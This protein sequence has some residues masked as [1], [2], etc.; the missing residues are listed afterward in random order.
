MKKQISRLVLAIL[1]C[2]ML[3]VSCGG[4]GG[5]SDTVTVL[6]T[7]RISISPTSVDFGNVVWGDV[8]Y[9]TITVRNTGT[10]SSYLTISQ[11]AGLASPYSIVNDNCTGRSL[12]VSGS[13]T[14][15]AR[16]APTSGS[17]WTDSLNISTNDPSQ[18][19]KTV[20]VA[21]HARGLRVHINNVAWAAYPLITLTM[22][23]TN[24]TYVPIVGLQPVDFTLR[25]NG[26][27]KNITG[28]A[29]LATPPPISAALA[30][31]QSIS[32]Q[33][34][35]PDIKA[36]SVGFINALAA[37]DRAEIIKFA[38]TIDVEQTFITANA[39]NKTLLINAINDTYTTGLSETHLYDALY[40][41]IDDTASEPDTNIRAV[42]LI[43]DGRDEDALGR[44]P[45]STIYTLAE[46]IAHAKAEGISIFTIGLG[47][48]NTTV[49]NQLASETGGQ[50]FYAPTT[51]DISTIYGNIQNILTG[52]YT[53]TYTTGLAIGSPVTLDV[54]VT[55]SGV[56]GQ[57][58]RQLVV[59]P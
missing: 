29:A 50:Y 7:P 23:V 58:I 41:A 56:D 49:M 17:V 54:V 18:F 38:T 11:I 9:Q 44:H 25:E 16:F 45:G 43:S 8:S 12:A 37:I 55:D 34:Y 30:L 48:V 31:D 53:V 4:G 27:G 15:E 5:G 13:C 33:Q 2:L 3:M 46:V 47:V 26:V 40:K 24:S 6:P 14:F 32:M 42:I 35:M 1:C 59:G 36:A 19:T 51:A 10:A 22:R 57:A 39:G 21:G 20:S 28:V 52:I